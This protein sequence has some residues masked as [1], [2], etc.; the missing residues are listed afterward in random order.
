MWSES[1][2]GELVLARNTPDSGWRE[3]LALV[4]QSVVALEV[5][6]KEKMWVSLSVIHQKLT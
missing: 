4:D 6:V 5:V 1:R 2:A 3:G